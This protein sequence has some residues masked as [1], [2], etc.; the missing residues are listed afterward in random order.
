WQPITPNDAGDWINQRTDAFETYQ[1]LGDRKQPGAI[2][3]LFCRGLETGRDPWVYNADSETVAEN[4]S[5]TIHFYNTEVDRFA[6]YVDEHQIA[7]PKSAVRDFL[8]YDATR[9][10][11]ARSLR[12]AVVKG[13]RLE[14]SAQNLMIGTYRPF[15]KQ[16]VYYAPLLNHERS[17]LPSMFPTP[18]HPNY[19]FTMTGAGSHFEFSLIATDC[20]PNLHLLDTGQFFAR[21]TYKKTEDGT[22][23]LGDAVGGYQQLDNI[24]DATLKT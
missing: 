21:Y 10:S 6:E 4:V 9:I 19:G 16:A 12:Q 13:I 24:T 8:D 15:M 23:D 7:D 22:L 14:Y 2:F 1:A 18:E 17:Q 3:G 20:L 11:W 5:R